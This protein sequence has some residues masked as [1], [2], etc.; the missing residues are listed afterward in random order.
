MKRIGYF[1]GVIDELDSMTIPL[2]DRSV[3]YGDTM[4]YGS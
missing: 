1:N 3:F 4:P 2:C